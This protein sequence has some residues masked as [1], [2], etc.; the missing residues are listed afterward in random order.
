[1]GPFVGSEVAPIRGLSTIAMVRFDGLVW[2]FGIGTELGPLK[3][4]ISAYKSID[5]NVRF[6]IDV[7]SVEFWATEFSNFQRSTRNISVAPEVAPFGAI[8]PLLL[9]DFKGWFGHEVLALNHW[10]LPFL[11]PN[12]SI[13]V[14]I[15]LGVAEFVYFFTR[16]IN[17]ITVW[18]R[19]SQW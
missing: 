12:P 16:R 9:R 1:M 13:L 5:V 18:R 4:A 2:A 15:F 14:V 8:S 10:E 3:G 11:R 6:A 7:E 19:Y 17:M